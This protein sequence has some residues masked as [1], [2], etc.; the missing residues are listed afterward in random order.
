[1]VTS[2]D[3]HITG[4]FL[5]RPECAS[6]TE[7]YYAINRKYMKE[8]AFGFICGRIT[9]QESFA[10]DFYPDLSAYA[11]VKERSDFIPEGLGGF[12]AVSFD[13]RG[14]LGWRSRKIA[15]PDGDPG[16]D[17][18]EI[19]EVLS[20]AADGRYLAYLRSLGIP[21]IFAG[22]SEIDVRLALT[23]LKSLLSCETLVLEGGS[24]ING[25]FLRA[26][27]VDEI[28]LVVSPTVAGASSAPL[29][30]GA[31]ISDFVLVK[32]ENQNGN[33]V[34]NYKKSNG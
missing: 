7:I 24:I 33:L 27:A 4:E 34:L 20:E 18:A 25:A 22:E 30:S 15:D 29:F 13:T 31:E 21:Y 28:S 17:R 10:G 1:M 26:G 3:G 9:M 16:Y 32:S 6:A 11:E 14:S 8:G 23:K 19:V 5:R 12:Y 2:L